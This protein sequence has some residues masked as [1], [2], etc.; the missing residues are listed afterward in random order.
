MIIE[1][2]LDIPFSINAI[3]SALRRFRGCL[4]H[5]HLGTCFLKATVKALGVLPILKI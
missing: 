3:I 2:G 1:V 4:F 5:Q